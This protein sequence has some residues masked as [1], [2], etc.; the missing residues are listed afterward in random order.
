M[1]YLCTLFD[2]NYLPL[3]LALYESI[4]RNFGEFHLWI[5]PMDSRTYDFFQ[6][7]P[8]DNVT[9]LSL[10]EIESEEVLVA[11]RNRTWQE[12]CWTL[13]PILPSYI[14]EKNKNIGHITYLDS[15]IYFYSD[16]KPIYDE[17]GN[18]SVMII[19]H[20][21]PERLK[22]LEANGI[23][24][25]QMVYFNRDEIGMKCL[26]RWRE[27]CLEWCY[28]RVEDGKL[29]D[30]K[31]LDEWPEL[32][33]N[34]SVLKNE[35]SGVALWNV[36]N[37]QLQFSNGTILINEKPLIFYHFHMFKL[38]SGFLYGTGITSYNLKFSNL[39]SIYI[40]YLEHIF[41]I[42]S[43]YNI[44]LKKLGIFEILTLIERRNL[45]SRLFVKQLFLYFILFPFVPVKQVY[46][47][48]KVSLKRILTKTFS[49]D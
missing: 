15:D 32:Y 41:A 39:K 25:V 12:Y 44:Q 27:Q 1:K 17:I 45:Y 8:F 16:V 14:L 20:R 26:Y 47:K 6:I 21:F 34:V 10:D 9:V 33:E 35:Q 28:N 24:N 23:Y 29:G 18:A 13:S 49:K 22:Y 3:G 42:V 40:I 4:R 7:N 11:K 38:F 30:Q 2:Y 37:Y 48:A 19:P 5:L 46:L 43:R 36:E 31:Y